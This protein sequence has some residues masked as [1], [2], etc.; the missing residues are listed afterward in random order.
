MHIP[1][2]AR[3]QR[4][5]NLCTVHI[6]ALV[7]QHELVYIRVPNG[8]ASRFLDSSDISKYQSVTRAVTRASVPACVYLRYGGEP[9]WQKLTWSGSQVAPGTENRGMGGLM[10]VAEDRRGFNRERCLQTGLKVPVLCTILLQRDSRILGLALENL[11]HDGF[12]VRTLSMGTDVISR[13]EQLRP[14]LVIIATTQSRGR[15]RELC[16]G[17]REIRSLAQTPVILVAA[18]A[19]EEECILGLEAGADDFVTETLGWREIAARARAV[20]RRF[21]R[22]EL[23]FAMPHALP[24]F[25]HPLI[26][27]PGPA[28]RRGDIEIDPDAMRISVRGSEVPTTNLEF[29]LLYYLVHYEARVFSR[30]QLLDAV[31]GTPYVEP[32]SVD[33]CIRRLRRKIEPDPLRP[34][35]LK[36]VRGAG[37]RLLVRSG[38]AVPLQ[39]SV[40][41]IAGAAAD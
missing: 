6:P 26:G 35:Y 31:W 2:Q 40:H 4:V 23:R 16:R 21:A 34:T 14:C 10:Y 37:Y 27:P 15:A 5:K 20:I 11:E 38:S 18:N 22:H 13:V 25:W 32:R 17:I 3:A 41:A 30:D 1:L 24:A 7:L 8:K 39:S 12:G 28:L 33:A 36:T 29:R 19:S 9:T